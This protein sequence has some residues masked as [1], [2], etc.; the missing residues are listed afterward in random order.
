M[1]YF[2]SDNQTQKTNDKHTATDS[3]AFHFL[4]FSCSGLV[5]DVEDGLPGASWMHEKSTQKCFQVFSSNICKSL[6][7]MCR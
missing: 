1:L 7:L 4:F 6:V 5:D 3:A 2:L